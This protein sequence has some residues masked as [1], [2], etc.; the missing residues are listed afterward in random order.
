M[1]FGWYLGLYFGFFYFGW[2]FWWYFWCISDFWMR[3]KKKNIK[4]G[5]Y[6]LPHGLDFSYS[7]VCGYILSCILLLCIHKTVEWIK[8]MFHPTKQVSSWIGV[9]VHHLVETLCAPVL[10]FVKA[11]FMAQVLVSVNVP[12]ISIFLVECYISQEVQAKNFGWIPCKHP[13]PCIWR[14]VYQVMVLAVYR[15][16]IDTHCH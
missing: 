16:S 4:T 7:L 14:R 5:V 8:L 15:E 1:H 11:V 2:Y 3:G 6:P 9:F 10:I 12:H 13:F